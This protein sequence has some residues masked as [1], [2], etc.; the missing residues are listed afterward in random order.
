MTSVERVDVLLVEDDDDDAQYVERL[1]TAFGTV[2]EQLVDVTAV[3]RAASLAGARESLDWHPDLVLLDLN[4]PD[5]DGLDTLDAVVEDAPHVPVVVITGRQDRALGPEAIRRGA[6][7]YLQKG[8]LTNELVHRTLRYALDRQR[9]HRE[10]TR[11]NHR[12]SLLNHIVRQDIRDDLTVV[13]G[14]GDEL[15]RRVAPGDEPLAES[16]LDA[17][18]HAIELTDRADELL[19]VLSSDEAPECTSLDVTAVVDEEVKRMRQRHDTSIT[20]DGVSEAIVRATP[21]L[22]TAI[23]ELL[24]NA[25][26]HNDS[27]RPQVTVTVERA[28]S[29]VQVHVED[30]GIGIPAVQR[31]LLNDPDARYHERAG[32]GTGLYL[33]AAVVEQAG[34]SLHFGTSGGGTVVTV[35]LPRA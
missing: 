6:Q 32:L 20:V 9:K 18:Q 23:G 29:D 7:D 24:S 11:L 16:L 13:V 3:R 26:R 28:D 35:T 19:T 8:H 33:A 34:G 21:M 1:L 17:A 2:E 22:G 10:I 14:R 4:L 25:I 15:Q 31:D 5:S 12:L 30:D 27:D